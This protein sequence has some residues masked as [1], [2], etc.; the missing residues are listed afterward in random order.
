MQ[1]LQRYHLQ[2]YQGPPLS[3]GPDAVMNTI[4]RSQHSTFDSHVLMPFD[5]FKD[6]KYLYIIMPFL[7]G[8]DLND[9]AWGKRI[10]EEE[11]RQYLSQIIKGMQ[12]LQRSGISHRDL[13]IENLLTD[14]SQRTVVFDFG[15]S[16]KIT[17]MDLDSSLSQH[18]IDDHRNAQ[19]CL[20]KRQR[21]CGNK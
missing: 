4:H 16:F 19:R 14:K 6:D 7:D 11:A 2:T 10:T 1:Y 17:Y 20:I 9:R 5:V 8:G 15:M 3:E 21:R 13:S 18:H 12:F